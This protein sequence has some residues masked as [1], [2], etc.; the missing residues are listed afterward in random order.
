MISAL[1]SIFLLVA[2]PSSVIPLPVSIEN[3]IGTYELP[4]YPTYSISGKVDGIDEFRAYLENAIPG[5]RP[6]KKAD[7]NFILG[8]KPAGAEGY[9][10]VI[11][12]KGIMVQADGTTGAFYALQTLLQL[13]SQGRTLQCAVTRDYPRYGYRAFM[14]DVS[15][16]WY[17]VDFVKRQLD[18]MARMKMNVLHLRLNGAAGWR[19]KLDAYPELTRKSNGFYTKDDIRKIIKY[20]SQRH[21][22]VIPEIDLCSG[23]PGSMQF[24]NTVID[25]IAELSPSRYFHIG[26]SEPVTESWKEWFIAKVVESLRAHGKTAMG[27]DGI[28]I[29]NLS[30][31]VVLEN[32]RAGFEEPVSGHKTILAPDRHTSLDCAQDAPTVWPEARFQ[33]LPL[34]YC[35]AFLPSENTDVIGLEACLWSAL[36]PTEQLAE[37]MTYPRLAAVAERAWSQASIRN[38]QKFKE[39]IIL[40]SSTW[41]RAGINY[42]DIRKEFGHRR[43]SLEGIPDNMAL[44][45]RFTSASPLDTSCGKSS[46]S[47]LTDGILGDWNCLEGR[48]IGFNGEM[49]VTIDLG[50]DRFIHY[51]GATFAINPG[52]AAVLPGQVQLY[53]SSD[54]ISWSGPLLQPCPLAGSSDRAAY[55]PYQFYISSLARFVRFRA[56][57]EPN[58]ENG[59]FLT[60]EI[61][62]R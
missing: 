23:D 50:R 57:S 15:G 51:V 17:G 40:L 37:F 46:L 5:V 41:D 27:W 22:E 53:L 39:R 19:I 9:R 8:I 49:D 42:F 16:N 30:G 7:I 47:W 33:Y 6:A 55:V 20:A 31:D 52:L 28:A 58:A 11:S 21:I 14:L 34:D 35:Y 59:L 26:G 61:I 32:R 45:C 10:L 60:D 18:E 24:V 25:E 3:G 44:G 29:G 43:E 1:L 56:L 48:W 4:E 38:F 13:L 62:I 12:S 36:C 54:G 2:H